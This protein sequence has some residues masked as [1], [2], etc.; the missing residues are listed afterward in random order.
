MKRTEINKNYK[1]NTCCGDVFTEVAKQAKDVS[2]KLNAI[3]EFDFNE[4]LCLVDKET[5]LE[6]IYRDYMNAHLM[7]WDTIGPN[8]DIEYSEIIKKEKELNEAISK[9]ESE[10]RTRINLAESN[11]EK[12]IFELKTAG[13]NIE[14]IDVDGWNKTLEKNSS[15]YGKAAMDFAEGWAKLMQVEVLK[16]SDIK[17]CADK[18]S[19]ELGFLGITGFQYG[20][21]KSLLVQCWKYGKELELIK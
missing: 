6:L 5:N 2:I 15:G 16:G 14:L 19:T 3:V 13:I 4:I 17:D 9:I 18:T 21:A 10:K 12:Q 7:K 20:C 11:A 1:L 8:C